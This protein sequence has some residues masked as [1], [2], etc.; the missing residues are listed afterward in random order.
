VHHPAG[1]PVRRD[2]RGRT[3]RAPAPRRAHRGTLPRGRSSPILDQTARQ[4]KVT[5]ARSDGRDSYRP[6]QGTFT[7]AHA[8]HPATGGPVPIYVADY[9]VAAYGTGA[10]MGVPAHTSATG[11]VRP[12]GWTPSDSSDPTSRAAGGHCRRSLARGGR[13][14][15][16]GSILRP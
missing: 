15:R 14:D 1:H 13:T 7:G 12:G 10:V 6:A 8:L 9:V 16:L 3:A 5:W 4:R 11:G 2:L